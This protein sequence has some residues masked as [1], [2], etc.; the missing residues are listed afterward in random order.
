LT[1][2]RYQGHHLPVFSEEKEVVM[3]VDHVSQEKSQHRRPFSA[4]ECPHRETDAVTPRLKNPL[5]EKCLKQLV[6]KGD[7]PPVVVP[8]FKLGWGSSQARD[9]GGA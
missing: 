1:G 6:K 9:P 7:L 3:T 8:I 5:I 2:D 4:S